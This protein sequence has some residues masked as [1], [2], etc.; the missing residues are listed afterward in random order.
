MRGGEKALLAIADLMPDAPIYT[1]VADRGN[2][3]D[4]L[5]R[6]DIRTSFLQK[7]PNPCVTYRSLLPLLPT[8]A[9]SLDC[10]SYDVV[11][12]SD[13][14]VIKGVRCAPEALKICYCYSPMRY[15]WDL[16]KAYMESVGPFRRLGLSLTGDPLRRWDR[17]AASTVTAFAA[18]SA[19]VADRI[20]RHYG[21][22]SVVIYPPVDIPASPSFEAPDDFYLVLGQQVGYKR[23]DL[24][25][26]A[27]NALRRRL[28]VIG[29]GGDLPRLRRLAGPTVELL[30]RQDDAVVRSH[31]RR[32]RA[33][34]FCGEE[35]FG[36]VPVEAQAAGRS[37]IAYGIGGAAETVRNRETG[38]LFGV[39]S[40]DAVVDAIR[41]FERDESSFSP[42]QCFANARRFAAEAFADRFGRFLDVCVAAYDRGG[43]Q[44]VRDETAELAPDAFL[45]DR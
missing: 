21:R 6:R 3:V 32:C 41:R 42:E 43:P 7:L 28:V 15:L 39:Q 9:G 22:N 8:A 11:L 40:P 35:D 2:L 33:L 4:R 23:T 25:I 37:V 14:S 18:I 31:M 36:L 30:G 1:L 16:K 5:G 20:R 10:R 12:C 38:V 17:A 26:D 29:E 44:A 34:L 27:C 13:A 19:H 45:N 24:A